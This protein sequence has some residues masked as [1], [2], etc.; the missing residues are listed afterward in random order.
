[1]K[2]AVRRLDNLST[3]TLLREASLRE[4]RRK[5]DAYRA[6]EDFEDLVLV[7]EQRLKSAAFLLQ[8]LKIIARHQSH[9]FAYR[10]LTAAVPFRKLVAFRLDREQ[11][12]ENHFHNRLGEA[13]VDLRAVLHWFGL[14]SGVE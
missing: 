1:M 9:S 14:L 8:L 2:V 6:A 5:P 10:Q 4:P 3:A 13:F 7:P 11:L 12:L